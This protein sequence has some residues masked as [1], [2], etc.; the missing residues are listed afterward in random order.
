MKWMIYDYRRTANHEDGGYAGVD[1]H[2]DLLV[3]HYGVTREIIEAARHRRTYLLNKLLDAGYTIHMWAHTCELFF[4]V[5]WRAQPRATTTE[6]F[7]LHL[8]TKP[9]ES[10]PSDVLTAFPFQLDKYDTIYYDSTETTT[11][12]ESDTEQETVR[13]EIAAADLSLDE[14]R[15][16]SAALW[17]INRDKMCGIPASRLS[18]RKLNKYYG[19][20]NTGAVNMASIALTLADRGFYV[21]L[22]KCVL[23]VFSEQCPDSLSAI[24]QVF[25]PRY[26]SEP[27]FEFVFDPESKE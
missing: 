16:L 11:D 3:E 21:L 18:Y 13:T 23:T 25:K 8:P 1:V 10:L 22:S 9:L 26:M 15:F 19:L 6:P 4:T 2:H 17:K 14:L 27:K 20:S 12:D 5:E 24:G 7:T